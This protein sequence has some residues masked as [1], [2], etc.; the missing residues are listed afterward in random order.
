MKR[1]VGVYDH[2][3]PIED[4][5]VDEAVPGHP[6]G[7]PSGRAE[8]ILQRDH[9]SSGSNALP[10]PAAIRPTRGNVRGDRDGNAQTI[11]AAAAGTP[12]PCWT[13]CAP[14]SR[15]RRLRGTRPESWS[16]GRRRL[17]RCLT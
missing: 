7:V 2:L 9:V 3:I 13:A 5:E 16:S 12:A 10:K 1:L 15:A 11:P 6:Q 4:S 14:P 8:P 17:G